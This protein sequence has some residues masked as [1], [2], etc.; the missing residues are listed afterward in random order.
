M[1][2]QIVSIAILTGL[3]LWGF[4]RNSYRTLQDHGVMPN[5][6]VRERVGLQ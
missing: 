2:L 3:L 1:K 5:L 6:H 4:F